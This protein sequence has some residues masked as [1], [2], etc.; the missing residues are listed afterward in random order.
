MALSASLHAPYG[1]DMADAE[2]S[3]RVEY[4]NGDD[5]EIAGAPHV[6]EAKLIAARREEA[7]CLLQ[8]PKGDEIRVNPETVR[9]LTVAPSYGKATS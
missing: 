6:V 4:V 7:F 9:A 8:T 3:T 1:P 5:E 2:T